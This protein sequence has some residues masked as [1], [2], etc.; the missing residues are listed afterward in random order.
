MLFV[1]FR[2]GFRRS[3]SFQSQAQ[4]KTLFKSL[5]PFLQ[6]GFVRAVNMSGEEGF[7]MFGNGFSFLSSQHR[8]IC[9]LQS[10]GSVIRNAAIKIDSIVFTAER[11]CG[12]LS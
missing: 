6:I 12:D 11:Q 8:G 9:Q 4:I 1:L 5:T 3:N 10:D 7:Q 2:I